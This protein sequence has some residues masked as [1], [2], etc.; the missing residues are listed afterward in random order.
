MT[1]FGQR[2]ATLVPSFPGRRLVAASFILGAALAGAAVVHE[3]RV[4][5]MFPCPVTT[6]NGCEIIGGHLVRPDWVDP[7]ALG[8][9]VI[10]VAAAVGVLVRSSRRFVAAVLVSGAAVAISVVLAG[11]RVVGAGYAC[12]HT[13]GN[14]C[15]HHPRP[16]WVVP[17]MAGIVVLGLAGAAS[18]L[19]ATRRRSK[20]ESGSP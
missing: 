13:A 3:H 8:I 10:G 1:E 7:L 16:F 17:T 18:I 6:L 20:L 12:P 4:F 11:Y 15:F 5:Q 2:R 19:V 14:P 9:L